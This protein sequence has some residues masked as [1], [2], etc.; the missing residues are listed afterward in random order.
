MPLTW[1]LSG[2]LGSQQRYGAFP[3]S[4]RT[5]SSAATE[6]VARLFSKET[7]IFGVPHTK[8]THGLNLNRTSFKRSFRPPLFARAAFF[9]SIPARS[10]FEVG[11]SLS[12]KGKHHGRAHSMGAAIWE[13]TSFA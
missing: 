10:T 13:P 8:Q 11:V 1:T 2:S 3:P 12:A 4:W 5:P 9:V 7:T 6:W